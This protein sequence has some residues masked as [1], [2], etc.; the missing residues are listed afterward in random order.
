MTTEPKPIA[1][2]TKIF[3]EIYA[4]ADSSRTPEQVWI[5]VTAHA[6]SMGEDIRTF[7]F[8]KLL[9]SASHAFCWLCSFLTKCSGLKNDVFAINESLPGVVSLKYP[10]ACG[11]CIHNP[12]TC[13][14][15]EI[16]KK[17]DKAARYENL[18]AQRNLCLASFENYSIEQ[19]LSM[20]NGIYAAR[21]HIQ[22]LE[23]IGFHFL[24]EVGH[25][26]APIKSITKYRERLGFWCQHRISER[27][28]NCQFR[29]K[30]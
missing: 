22:T 21:T 24:E 14:P 11:H 27:A 18:I 15:I 25:C 29:C 10:L 23:S 3:S 16:D 4:H 26:S 7:S 19:C 30:T 20:F 17:S 28:H 13:N 9:F 6:S 5:A 8:D 1:V 2:W 12:C